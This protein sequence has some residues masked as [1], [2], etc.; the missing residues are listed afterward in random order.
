[1]AVRGGVAEHH[2]GR[3]LRADPQ[4]AS[5]EVGHQEGPPDCWVRLRDGREVTVECKNASPQLYADG[6]PKVEV[7]KTR[8]SQGDPASRYY[9]PQA[10]EILA[11]CMYGPTGAWTFRFRRS[12]RLAPHP[13]QAGRI[14]PLQR[15]DD[16]W[17]GTLLDALAEP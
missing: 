15:I 5:A 13:E 12:D 6:T 3:L 16:A 9:T 8:A 4:V 14:T 1:M 2:L 10:F 11:A 7:Q 17:S